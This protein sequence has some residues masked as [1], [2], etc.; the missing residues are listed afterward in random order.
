MSRLRLLPGV[1][2]FLTSIGYTLAVTWVP[3]F[4]AV[5]LPD[6]PTLSSYH[7]FRRAMLAFAFSVRYGCT[8]AK[9]L[10]STKGNYGRD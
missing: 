9:G 10:G 7:A 1:M 8:A 3:E 2:G 6:G 4:Q 5:N